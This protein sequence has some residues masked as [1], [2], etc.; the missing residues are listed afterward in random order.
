MAAQTH[1]GISAGGKNMLQPKGLIIC[2]DSDSRRAE[3]RRLLFEQS[4]YEVVV[5]TSAKTGLEL[6]ALTPADIAL[7]D[8][9]LPPM[10]GLS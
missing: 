8:H 5:A 7:V 1:R 3:G 6:F 4:G 2:I 10:M 9:E